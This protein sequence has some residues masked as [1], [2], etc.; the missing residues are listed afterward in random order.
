MSAVHRLVRLF[1]LLAFLA[2][3]ALSVEPS[4]H[5]V[6][7]IAPGFGYVIG[8]G[9]ED[10]AP[11]L[12]SATVSVTFWA[13]RRFGFSVSA[14][15]GIGQDLYDEPIVDPTEPIGDIYPREFRGK[16]GLRYYRVTM[17][18]PRHLSEKVEMNLGGG[19]FFGGRFRKIV[20]LHAPDG[21]VDVSPET[22]FGGFSA[23]LLFGRRIAQ[24]F[25][26]KSGAALDFNGETNMLMPMIQMVVDF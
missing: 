1:A 5:P 2:T 15:Y 4:H 25:A 10:P 14:I 9:G 11:A 21:P 20:I 16:E 26:V 13:S 8:G 6:V 23:E 19:I 22:Q 12:T 17:R 7:E 3:D 18:Y 24:H